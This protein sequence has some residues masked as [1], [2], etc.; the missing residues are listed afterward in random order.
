MNLCEYVGLDRFV[1]SLTVL[2]KLH[3]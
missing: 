3:L 2:A 1:H